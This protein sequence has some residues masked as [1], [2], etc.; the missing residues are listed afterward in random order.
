MYEEAKK[1]HLQAV[2]GYTDL[3]SRAK[4]IKTT[5]A[6]ILMF[7]VPFSFFEDMKEEAK[8]GVFDGQI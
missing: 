1:E 6:N 5:L 4:M 2:F 3:A 7:V 8:D